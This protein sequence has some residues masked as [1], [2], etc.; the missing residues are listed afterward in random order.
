MSCMP[1]LMLR[2][3]CVSADLGVHWKGSLLVCTSQVDGARVPRCRVRLASSW[4]RAVW[5]LKRPGWQSGMRVWLSNSWVLPVLFLATGAVSVTRSRHS[6]AS[7]GEERGICRTL[8]CPSAYRYWS[9]VLF[10]TIRICIL[11]QPGPVLWVAHA[12]AGATRP[13]TAPRTGARELRGRW[14]DGGM[15]GWRGESKHAVY[16]GR[17]DDQLSRSLGSGRSSMCGRGAGWRW[18]YREWSGTCMAILRMRSH[19]RKPMQVCCAVP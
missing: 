7:E 18:N 12:K 1:R 3:W 2:A 13:G 9:E 15:E 4:A 6:S 5:N 10:G 19:A 14:W 16:L 17:V 11:S 8:I